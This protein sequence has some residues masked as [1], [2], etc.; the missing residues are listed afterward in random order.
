MKMHTLA[1]GLGG[2]TL[3]LSGT[4][5]TAH[6]TSSPSLDV[7]H[8][9][10]NAPGWVVTQQKRL[11]STGR[12]PQDNPGRVTTFIKN[13]Q[14]ITVA[15]LGSQAL[16]ITPTE[17]ISTSSNS[18]T[19]D[20]SVTPAQAD[21]K[22]TPS[23]N[24]AFSKNELSGLIASSSGMAPEESDSWADSLLQGTDGHTAA[25][26]AVV[27][28][29]TPYQAL[30]VKSDRKEQYAYGCALLI[31]DSTNGTDW[32]MIEKLKT[33]FYTRGSRLPKKYDSFTRHSTANV[34][35]DWSP[36]YQGKDAGSGCFTT[37][38]GITSDKTG[39]SFNLSGEICQAS[40]APYGPGST[41]GGTTWRGNVLFVWPG[42]TYGSIGVLGVHSPPQAVY[43]PQFNLHSEWLL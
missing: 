28:N 6:A 35:Y 11:D 40:I 15:S 29:A 26:S 5:L 3:A 18:A 2:V 32:W 10:I 4:T 27:S 19:S 34:V 33:S 24:D 17:S 30:C 9:S 12:A 13:D 41:Y 39:F 31:K 1:L 16:T 23:N 37:T 8:D 25:A 21:L 36:Y 20:V 7:P 14:R 43:R 22:S 42:K 38:S